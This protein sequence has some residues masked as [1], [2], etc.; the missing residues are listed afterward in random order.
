MKK[1]M[2]VAA[3]ILASIATVSGEIERVGRMEGSKMKLYWWPKLQIPKGWVHDEELSFDKSSNMLLPKGKTFND[4]PTLIYGRAFYNKDKVARGSFK[5]FYKDDLDTMRK[6]TENF[7]I[8]QV[9]DGLKDAKGD[10]LPTFDCHYNGET[11]DEICYGEEEGGDYRTMIIM[12]ST[13]KEAF[14][15]DL[16]TYRQIVASYK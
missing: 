16:P 2:L 1:F 5:D 14:A 11:Y 10:V 9:K 6:N 7:Q 8:T 15:K 12:S 13:S 4:A 3:I